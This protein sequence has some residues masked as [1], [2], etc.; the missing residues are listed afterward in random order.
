ME[1]VISRLKGTGDALTNA[2]TQL[3]SFS[4]NGK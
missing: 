4:N 1:S 2:L 3:P